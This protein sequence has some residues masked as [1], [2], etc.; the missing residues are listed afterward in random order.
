MSLNPVREFFHLMTGERLATPQAASQSFLAAPV[1]SMPLIASGGQ[2]ISLIE[3]LKSITVEQIYNSIIKDQK[4]I[5]WAS[6]LKT[7][8]QTGMELSKAGTEFSA[9]MNKNDPVERTFE[10]LRFVLKT[11]INLGPESAKNTSEYA[12]I[13]E[14]HNDVFDILEELTHLIIAAKKKK[15]GG[16]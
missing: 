1:L 14:H 12:L 3:A 4:T 2:R 10:L 16:G 13:S 8:I 11:L 6:T 15:R 7:L 9:A 5:G